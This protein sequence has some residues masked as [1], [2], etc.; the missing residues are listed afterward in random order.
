MNYQS[1]D[2]ASNGVT[3]TLHSNIDKMKSLEIKAVEKKESNPRIILLG[4]F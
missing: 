4:K 1:S 2:L 3:V